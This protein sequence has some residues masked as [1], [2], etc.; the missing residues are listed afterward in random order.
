M[1]SSITPHQVQVDPSW[2]LKRARMRDAPSACALVRQ[3]AEYLQRLRNMNEKNLVLRGRIGVDGSVLCLPIPLMSRLR[4]RRYW[5]RVVYRAGSHWEMAHRLLGT[6]SFTSYRYQNRIHMT[7][8]QRTDLQF[9][10]APLD[11]L[12]TLAISLLRVPRSS[13]ET[14]NNSLDIFEVI[15]LFLRVKVMA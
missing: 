1:R 10:V 13:L 2:S 6:K 8:G 11:S 7:F 5:R 3:E 15:P 9:S 12:M 14:S 4:S